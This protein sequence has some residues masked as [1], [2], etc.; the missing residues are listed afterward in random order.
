MPKFVTFSEAKKNLASI[1]KQV[2]DSRNVLVDVERSPQ[3]PRLIIGSRKI[4]CALGVIVCFTTIS[5]SV[6]NDLATAVT[7][8][9]LEKPISSSESDFRPDGG[10]EFASMPPE[11]FRDVVW[12]SVITGT[13]VAYGSACAPK[14]CTPPPT[15]RVENRVNW[16]PQAKRGLLITKDHNYAWFDED[17]SADRFSFVTDEHEGQSYRFTGR[18][19]TDGIFE[20]TKPNGIVLTGRLTKLTNQRIV[21]ENDVDFLW[22]SWGE[23]DQRTFRRVRPGVRN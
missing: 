15:P 16:K 20:D 14:P 13:D 9:G 19:L 2:I 3:K 7:V 11:Q 1:L 12:L 6:S 4:L 18:F 23:V 5:C 17:L 8:G 22:F 21:A 10:Y